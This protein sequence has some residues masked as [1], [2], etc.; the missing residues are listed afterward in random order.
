MYNCGS[1]LGRVRIVFSGI[2]GLRLGRSWF[3]HRR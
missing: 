1:F 2:G 3:G